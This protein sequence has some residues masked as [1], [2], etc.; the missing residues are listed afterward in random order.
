MSRKHNTNHVK[1]WYKCT[2]PKPLKMK[3]GKFSNNKETH[4]HQWSTSIDIAHHTLIYLLK[5]LFTSST[6]EE[7]STLKG[8]QL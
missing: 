2:I 7:G 6:E 3:K 1:K 8:G 5:P 4:Q